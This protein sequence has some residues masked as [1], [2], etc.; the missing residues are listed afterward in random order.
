ME[1]TI[2]HSVG[3]W[4]KGAKNHYHDVITV[5]T[6]LK[7]AAEELEN[8]AIDPKGIDGKIS[9][10]P[11]MSAT[12]KAISAFQTRF[13]KHPDKL[14]EPGKTTIKKLAALSPD[15]PGHVPGNVPSNPIV[16]AGDY[17]FPLS[18]VPRLD[19]RTGGR[20]FGANRSHGTR[21]HAACDLI[22][23]EGTKIYAVHD[24]T[25]IRGPYYFYRGTY[26]IEVNHGD[27]IARYCEIKK[28]APGV[29][30]GTT[31]SGGQLIAFVGKMYHDSML[32]FELYSGAA[33]GH[34]TQRNNPPYQRRSDLLNPTP[35]LEMWE[36][37]LPG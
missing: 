2:S 9:K 26:A 22:A 29:H 6:L 11:G 19:F 30:V 3:S 4:E 1:K 7:A 8:P 23:P 27:F 5:Q 36:K 32:H 28:T 34:L 15:Q 16:N 21:K 25:V 13:M 20:R 14:I 33:S 24:G 12:V 37:R 18:F 31:V 35:Y 17:S 10:T